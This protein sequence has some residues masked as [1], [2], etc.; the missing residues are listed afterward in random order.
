M[1]NL[2]SP[3]NNQLCHLPFKLAWLGGFFDGEGT[4]TVTINDNKHANCI[5]FA[6][7]D[8]QCLEYCKS[9]LAEIG[10]YNC[11][12]HNWLGKDN[13]KRTHRLTINKTQECYD[14]AIKMIDYT[15]L[16]RDRLIMFKKYLSIKLSRHYKNSI[17]TE[18][19]T[20]LVEAI[21]AANK[22]GI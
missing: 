5:Y 9:V 11:G 4:V 13:W 12:I 17:L 3:L 2:L 16:K 6:N 10:I 21:R 1:Q 19:Q 22:R 15:V 20:A 8:L 14:F 7:T 18:E